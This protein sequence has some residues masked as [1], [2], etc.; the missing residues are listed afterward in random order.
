MS[1]VTKYSNNKTVD[2]T[3]KE[4]AYAISKGA[5]LVFDKIYLHFTKTRLRIS[6]GFRK[7]L[8]NTKQSAKI[9]EHR[10]IYEIRLTHVYE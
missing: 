10:F 1:G 6:V 7:R 3:N 5:M 4:Q 2:F 9:Q 8:L